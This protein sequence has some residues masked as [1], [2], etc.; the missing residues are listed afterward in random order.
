MLR[1]EVPMRCVVGRRPSVDSSLRVR[2]LSGGWLCH[3]MLC[4]ML[5][6]TNECDNALPLRTGADSRLRTASQ[7]ARH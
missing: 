3:V 7:L 4:R 2:A 6:L 1:L 5:M